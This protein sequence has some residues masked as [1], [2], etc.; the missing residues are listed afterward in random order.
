MVTAFI[1]KH[2]RNTKEWQEAEQAARIELQ[3]RRE[4]LVAE[5]TPIRAQLSKGA[6]ARGQRIQDAQAEVA[7]AIEALTLAQREQSHVHGEARSEVLR[8]E[9]EIARREQELRATCPEAVRSFI[10]EVNTQH[11]F[12]RSSS[13]NWPYKE[14]GYSQNNVSRTGSAPDQGKMD[15]I[16]G[17]YRNARIE[18]EGLFLSDDPNIEG[19]VEGLRKGLKATLAQIRQET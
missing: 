3:E 18:A 4:Q 10:A 13:S 8:A 11:E 7:K 2:L 6:P 17:A 9:G 14:L 1:E 15:A 19:A 5:I 12:F 16:H